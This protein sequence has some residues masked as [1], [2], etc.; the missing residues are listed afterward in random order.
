[1]LSSLYVFLWLADLRKKRK[2]RVVKPA[3]IE[4]REALHGG[5]A[6]AT[7]PAK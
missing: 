7:Q 2:V 4:V 5:F 3:F 6:I 1:M